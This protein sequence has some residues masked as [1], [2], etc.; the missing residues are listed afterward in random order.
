MINYEGAEAALNYLISTDEEYAR[1]KTLYDALCEQKKT[2]AAIEYGK[3]TGTAAEKTQRALASDNYQS[4]LQA[5]RD[6][7]IEFETVRARRI[8]NQAV[9]EMWRSVNSARNKGNI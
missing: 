2:I 6:A 1:A 4:H 7:Q 3:L 5:I 9:I 8:S